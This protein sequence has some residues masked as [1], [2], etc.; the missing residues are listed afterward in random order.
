MLHMLFSSIFVLVG[1]YFAYAQK[2]DFAKKFLVVIVAGIFFAQGVY[3]FSDIMISLLP[4]EIWGNIQFH[5]FI[6]TKVVITCLLFV[7]LL[8]HSKKENIYL[9]IAFWLYFIVQLI[10]ISYDIF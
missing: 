8:N 6:A 10:D 1:V 7:L 4:M 5:I 9:V 3:A 2:N